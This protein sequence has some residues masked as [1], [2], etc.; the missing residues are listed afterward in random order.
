MY[1]QVTE[2]NNSITYMKAVAIISMVLG[3][4]H[5]S[6]HTD[7]VAFVNQFH[8]PIFF[9]VSGFC[10]KEKYLEKPSSFIKQRI[11]GLWLPFVKWGGVFPAFTQCFLLPEYIQ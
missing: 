11:T 6:Y 7:L 9:F 5:S 10:F 2:R 4:A 3:H 8:M 1:R